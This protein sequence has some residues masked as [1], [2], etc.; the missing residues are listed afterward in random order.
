MYNRHQLRVILPYL[1][2]PFIDTWYVIVYFI[3]YAYFN[4]YN[5]LQFWE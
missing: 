2:W 4:V 1:I 3:I 5:Q